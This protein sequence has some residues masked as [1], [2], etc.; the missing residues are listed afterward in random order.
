MAEAT[1]TLSAFGDEIA[2]D[3][4][5]QLDLLASEG[6][7]HLELR[8]AWGQNV[9]ALDDAQL[10]R[11]AALL[12]ERGFGVSAIGSP[13]GKSGL[14]QPPTFELDRLE[15]AIAAADALGTRL[16]RVFSFYV[17][18]GQA[19]RHRDEVLERMARL[20]ERAAQAGV[21]LVH[22]NEKGIYG[23]T[24]ER[25][26]DVLATIN[27]PALRMAFDPANFVQVGVRPMLEAWPILAEYTTHVH[28][29]DALLE[30]G[31]VRPAGAGD[32]EIP[33]L[34]A[35]LLAR[36]YQGFLTLEPHLKVAGPSGGFS[37]EA[38][39]RVAIQALRT[40]LNLSGVRLKYNER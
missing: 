8:G 16:I 29:K 15:R 20:T 36:G 5:T 40:V 35:A 25:C 2:D 4:A 14:D 32:G 13:I 24:A 7:Y 9:L 22:E 18:A 26:Q 27:A 17:P 12:R 38:G 11:A 30:D 33:E 23:D 1:F 10:A 6:I 37:G 19:A 3:L 21:T 28:I 39:M 34:I 31:S